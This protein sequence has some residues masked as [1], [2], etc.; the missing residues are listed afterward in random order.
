MDEDQSTRCLSH[1]QGKKRSL[2]LSVHT[3]FD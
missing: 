3:F 2:K 1:E